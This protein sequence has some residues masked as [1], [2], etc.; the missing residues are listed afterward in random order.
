[1]YGTSGGNP[2]KG[3]G[4]NDKLY[5]Q[6]GDHYLFGGNGNDTLYGGSGKDAF[7]FDTKPNKNTNKDTIKD[8]RVVDDTIRLDNAVFLKVGGNGT[9]KASAFWTNT[10]GKAHDKEGTTGSSTIRIVV[11]FIMTLTALERVQR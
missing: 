3:Y 2:L 11:F 7:V 8:F 1:M 9:L 6:G 10:T 4:S 5:G